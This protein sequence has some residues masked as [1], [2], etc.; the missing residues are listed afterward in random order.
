[1]FRTFVS[2]LII[3]LILCSNIFGGIRGPGIYWGVVVFDRWD[4]CYLYSGVYL[5]YVAEEKKELLRKYEGQSVSVYAEEVIQ[6]L[7][8]GDGRITEFKFLGAAETTKD[9]PPVEKL[10]LT[11]V[12]IFDG[13]NRVEF[14]LEIENLGDKTV[15]VATSEIAPTLFGERDENY[16]LSPSDGKSEAKITGCNIKNANNFR[17]ER[18]FTTTDPGGRLVRMTEKFALTVADADPA[19]DSF[20]LAAGQKSRFVVSLDIAPGNYEFLFGYG[21]DHRGKSLVSNRVSFSLDENG[22]ARVLTNKLTK[23]KLISALIKICFGNF[24]AETLFS[25]FQKL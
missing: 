18:G 21:G 4:T 20:Q 16:G 3:A 9:W 13:K 12:P 25:N 23:K 10:K 22:K 7:N 15:S 24:S 19:A 14:G 2:G 1:M 11:A 5:T 17:S 8:P 6:P